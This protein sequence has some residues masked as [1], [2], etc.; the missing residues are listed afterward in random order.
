VIEVIWL[1]VL[2]LLCY[3][4]KLYCNAF[5]NR[6]KRWDE[7][8]ERPNL[9]YSDIFEED[10]G[11]VPGVYHCI[12]LYLYSLNRS[13]RLLRPAEG[14]Q[15]GLRPP[16]DL[17]PT[18]GLRTARGFWGGLRPLTGLWPLTICNISSVP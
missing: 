14:P 7:A 5:C 3:E 11:Q 6:V 18:A 9:D 2:S 12:V 10:V 15:R 8:L 4:I 16:A 1:C 17:R 13:V